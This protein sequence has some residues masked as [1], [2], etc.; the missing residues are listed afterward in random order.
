[1]ADIFDIALEAGGFTTFVAAVQAA[2]LVETLKGR[3]PFT[4]F[5]PNDDAFAKLPAGTIDGLLK[6]KPKLKAILMYHIVVGKFTVDEIGQV[7]TMK[8]VQGQ[9]VKIDA[10]HWWTSHFNPLIDDAHII[11]TDIVT[12][13]GMIQ[14]L[15]GVLMPNMDLTCPVCGMGFMTMEAMDEHTKTGHIAEK[16]ATLEI[17]RLEERL[18]PTEVIT[19][20]MPI[21]EKAAEPVQTA[22]VMPVVEK[23]PEPM[24]PVQVPEPMLPTE[25]MPVVEKAPEPLP[26]TEVITQPISAEA[27][28]VFE[29][30]YDS[31]GTFR[32]HLKAANGQII[33]VSQ[34]YGTKESALK[35]I[36]SIKKNAPIAKTT[37]F[38]PGGTITKS[39][40]KPGIVQDTV[41]EIQF[42]APDRF[43][44]H[45][46]AANGQIIAVSQSYLS[47]QSAENGIASMKKNAPMAK[48]IDQT[49][50][51]T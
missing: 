16:V 12:D 49:I 31:A 6:N 5:V 22:E 1:M 34:A 42:N 38:A 47:K 37:D 45:L 23:A 14:V 11:N 44:F 15:N 3:G 9:E 7:K 36:A 43:R 21:T 32:F 19:E 28:G 4:I 27:T 50:A 13:N 20:K 51:M 35:G 40:H 8:T 41:F 18:P 2:G 26:P 46:K 33:A 25:V 30:I 48:I 29:I 10:A 17:D 24:P 39:T